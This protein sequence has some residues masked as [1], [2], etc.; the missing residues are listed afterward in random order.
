MR[1]HNT[2]RNILTAGGRLPL[3]MAALT[4]LAPLCSGCV[5]EM[6]TGIDP[7]SS[8]PMMSVNVMLSGPASYGGGAG[9]NGFES[10]TGA[11]NYLELTRGD[12]RI[13]FFDTEG[14]Y[15]DRFVTTGIPVQTETEDVNGVTTW[16]YHQF[17][18]A[19]PHDLPLAFKMVML[20]NW[21]VY[22]DTEGGPVLVP[23]ETTIADMCAHAGSRFT[24][25]TPDAD[26]NWLD[27]ES[28]RLIPF[29]GVREYDMRDYVDP[30]DIVD[31]QI[32]GD[33]FVDLSHP[34][35]SDGDTSLP[36]LRAMARVEVVLDNPFASFSDVRI[37]RVNPEGYCAPENAMLHTDYFHGYDWDTD[38]SR[39][40]H[41]PGGDNSPAASPVAMT[42]VPVA[43]GAPERWVA[44]IPEYRNAGAGDGFCSIQVTLDPTM[45]DISA[46]ASPAVRTIYFATGGSEAANKTDSR[47][48]RLPDGSF[49]QGR[50][51]IERNNIYR[52]TVTG[53]S[54]VPECK[55]EIQPYADCRI[56]VDYGLMR[57]S[58]GDLKV[59]PDADGELPDYFRSYMERW[60]DK[61][62]MA[63]DTG[64]PIQLL[65]GDYYAIVVGKDGLI[66]NAEVWVKDNGECRILTNLALPDETDQCSTRKVV[67]FT[68]D[69]ESVY[70]KDKHGDHRLQHNHDHSSVVYDTE[71]RMIYKDADNTWRYPVESWDSATGLFWY[72]KSRTP[73]GDGSVE[74]LFAEVNRDGAETGNT[75]T[76]TEQEPTVTELE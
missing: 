1:I 3:W 25:L 5:S 67:F 23:G 65:E 22:P 72:E 61:W 18:G 7:V 31:G 64:L 52:F 44:Y 32:R 50:F 13:Y 60:P 20:A 4:C 37:T 12:Y 59:V 34:R 40:P 62:P 24:R 29:Y 66:E 76:V 73:L 51:D 33:I 8:E 11:E 55:V 39:V 69:S 74:L 27:T 71:G 58:R 36:L 45:P 46:K 41:L 47:A 17:K 54:A 53:M 15:L 75:M 30:A 42:R 14:R 9:N 56:K 16:Y 2:Y 49:S 21:G 26:G 19:I 35:V 38:F 63:E 10:G 57:D 68:S 48:E 6:E 43:E 70:Y 28:G